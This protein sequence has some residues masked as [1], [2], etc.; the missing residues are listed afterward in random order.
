[1]QATPGIRHRGC[2]ARPTWGGLDATA[3]LP[4][5]P[6]PVLAAAASAS[7]S[8]FSIVA[9]FYVFFNATFQADAFFISE[10]S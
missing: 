3:K 10:V 7:R 6:N 4:T 8:L 5:V 9:S 2:L 1:M